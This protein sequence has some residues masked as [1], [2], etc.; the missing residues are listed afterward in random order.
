MEEVREE[1]HC[2]ELRGEADS[3]HREF[4]M[5]GSDGKEKDWQIE[6]M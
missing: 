5:F 1:A 6:C 3:K 4:M 2:S